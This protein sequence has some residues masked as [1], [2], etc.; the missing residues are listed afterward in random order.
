MKGYIEF[1]AKIK[2][3][4]PIEKKKLTPELIKVI[5]EQIQDLPVGMVLDGEIE[6]SK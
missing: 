1:T 3:Q 5:Q 4:Y 2:Y 6:V